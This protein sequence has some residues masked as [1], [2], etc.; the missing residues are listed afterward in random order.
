MSLAEGLP[1]MSRSPAQKPFIMRQC[2]GLTLSGLASLDIPLTPPPPPRSSRSSSARRTLR[3]SPLAGPTVLSDGT[4]K[5]SDDS[6]DESS[7][8]ESS[9]RKS[10]YRPSRISSNPDLR[11]PG[12]RSSVAS[13]ARST[14]EAFQVERYCDIWPKAPSSISS[15]PTT[16]RTIRPARSLMSL[17][18]Q[19]RRRGVDPPS[20]SPIPSW[21]LHHQR[22][23]DRYSPAAMARPDPFAASSSLARSSAAR[24]SPTR[25]PAQNW[26]STSYYSE[27][28]RSSRINLDTQEFVFPVSR[29][30]SLQSVSPLDPSVWHNRLSVATTGSVYSELSGEEHVPD[31]PSPTPCCE[32]A[33]RASQRYSFIHFIPHN[34]SLPCLTLARTSSDASMPVTPTSTLT[35][36]TTTSQKAKIIKRMPT[37]RPRKRPS[38]A[39]SRR[40]TAPSRRMSPTPP[41]IR[42]HLG[43]DRD[44]EVGARADVEEKSVPPPDP[45]SPTTLSPPGGAI[46]KVWKRLRLKSLGVISK[47]AK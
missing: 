9:N 25:N 44:S 27:A 14:P 21:A 10:R 42:V 41:R 47:I 32:T 38:T 26:L 46:V 39:P 29:S 31:I 5:T 13:V 28:P 17:S 18:S 40:V 15:E 2:S 7:A 22:G 33:Q 34:E 6:E 30:P 4:V 35:R 20:N 36:S 23:A 12:S 16:P 1:R 8:G 37:W 3:S 19:K 43:D 24:S 45:P 11:I